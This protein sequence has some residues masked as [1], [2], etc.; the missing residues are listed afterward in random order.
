MQCNSSS[1]LG[2]RAFLQLSGL[3][4]AGTCL[5]P[6]ANAVDSRVHVL[7]I[8]ESEIEL[9]PG[10]RFITTT[11]NDQFPGPV[12][13]ATVGVPVCVDVINETDTTEQIHWQGQELA[14]G[15]VLPR[16]R[17]RMEFTP[18]RAGVYLYHS[19]VVAGSDLGAGLYSGQSGALLVEPVQESLVVLKGCEPFMRR[20]G[21]GCEVGYSGVTLNGRLPGPLRASPGE[22]VLLQVLNAGAT[23]TY[24]LELPG[25]VFEV[26]ALDGNPLAAPVRVGALQLS[27]G[28]RVSARVVVNQPTRWVVRETDRAPTFLRGLNTGKPDETLPV[29]LT[30]HP[31]ARSGFNR[32]SMNRPELRVIA[33]ARYRLQIHN[34][35]DELIPLHLQRHRLQVHGVLKDVAV[36]GP[37]QRVEVDFEA[38]GR[39]SAL[40][41]CTRQLHS[42]FGLRARVDYT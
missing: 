20:T 29:M 6:F 28:E 2:R 1:L 31:A 16:S 34:T 13:R 33:G 15:V 19:E 24:H 23:E 26:T 22:R 17:R 7:R 21:R 35:S 39:G 30:R 25:H 5:G 18:S 40:L 14:C 36:V 38:D 10:Y 37:Q 41:H 11:Y 9:R 4:A 27:P 32:W 42:D 8:R 3:A 12:L